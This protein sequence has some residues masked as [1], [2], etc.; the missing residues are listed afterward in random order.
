MGIWGRAEWVGGSS[1]AL[2]LSE[3]MGARGEPEQGMEGACYTPHRGFTTAPLVS[4]H[5]KS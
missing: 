4:V 5:T 3:E 1:A 2:G